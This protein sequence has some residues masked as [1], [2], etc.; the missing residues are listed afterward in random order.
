MAFLRAVFNISV[1]DMDSG[2]FNRFVANTKLCVEGRG[3]VQRDADR[4]EKQVCVNFM[5][6]NK[7]KYKTEGNSM[8]NT[9]L[10]KEWI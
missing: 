2:N 6:F 5:K 7:A 9:C 8:T 3:A 10:G 4:L 1:W